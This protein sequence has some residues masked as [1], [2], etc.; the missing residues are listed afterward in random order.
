MISSKWLEEEAFNKEAN[1]YCYWKKDSFNRRQELKEHGFKYNGI[2]GWH[3]PI[4]MK[5]YDLIE[6]AATEVLD[7]TQAD[8]PAYLASAKDVLKRKVIESRPSLSEWIYKE[9]CRINNFPAIVE[10]VSPYIA[11]D[12]GSFRVITFKSGNDLLSWRTSVDFPYGKGDKVLLSARI[13]SHTDNDGEKVT[14]INYVKV[15]QI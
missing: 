8:A 1:T 15:K 14:N 11:G 3:S 2:L 4:N 10:E 5:E 9:D 6:V 13:K 7:C 12:W